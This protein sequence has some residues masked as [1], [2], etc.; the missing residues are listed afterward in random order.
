[1]IRKES[2]RLDWGHKNEHR[3]GYQGRRPRSSLLN[4]WNREEGYEKGQVEC[5]CNK[6]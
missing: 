6:G 1:M 4:K 3:K 5:D 2:Q